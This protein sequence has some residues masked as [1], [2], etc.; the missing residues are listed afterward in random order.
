MELFQ[1]HMSEMADLQKKNIG[2]RIKELRQSRNVKG[3]QLA[4]KAD[5]APQ[6]LSRIENGKHDVNMATLD[7]IL[8]AMGCTLKD[9]VIET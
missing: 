9:L 5:I 7:A 3:Y 4:K 6:S 1:E 2:K 8:K